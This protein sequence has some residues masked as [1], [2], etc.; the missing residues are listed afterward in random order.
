MRTP[1]RGSGSLAGMQRYYQ[2]HR[3]LV[4][5]P[6][7]DRNGAVEK[8]LLERVF[9]DLEI[10]SGAGAVLDVGC[11]SGL[12]APF[13]RERRADYTGLDI[14]VHP[15]FRTL[16]SGSVRFVK[17]S[18]LDLPFDRG[19]FGLVACVDSFEHYPDQVRAASEMKRVLRA[20][21]K[22][23]LSVPNY[24]NMAGWVKRRM[25]SRGRYAPDSWAPFD[26]WEPQELE[27][28][29]TPGLVRTVF[30]AA[31]FANFRMRGLSI[32][33]HFGLLP[34]LMHPACPHRL[35]RGVELL[36]RPFQGAVTARR[37]EWSLHTLW[38]IS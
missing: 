32:E 25:E 6:F 22:V 37:P 26:F 34:W 13:F 1:P 12:L 28:F 31:G 17:G 33:L 35:K 16:A 21:G 29:M 19:R 20:G 36:F 30:E 7:I 3:R 14:N 5:S 23:F 2:A 18:A 11:G 9:R 24:S 10:P 15:R 38:S 27:Q 4:T 8:G